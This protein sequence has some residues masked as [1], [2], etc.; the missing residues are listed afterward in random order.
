MAGQE[1]A[2]PTPE[3][4]RGNVID[5]MSALKASLEKRGVAFDADGR[6]EQSE[7]SSKAERTV[8][9]ERKAQP[10]RARSR[11]AR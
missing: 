1:I 6:G 4:H 2:E 11:G 9:E 7:K 3:A 10:K 5:L 8:S